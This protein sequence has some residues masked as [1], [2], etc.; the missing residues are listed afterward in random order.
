MTQFM[1]RGP[2]GANNQSLLNGIR[3][4]VEARLGDGCGA[5]WWDNGTAGEYVL[6]QIDRRCVNAVIRELKRR[7]SHGS[8]R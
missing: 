1:I 4:R 8:R 5:L 6:L 3:G 7:I 2:V